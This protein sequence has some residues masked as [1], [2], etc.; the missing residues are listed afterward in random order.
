MNCEICGKTTPLKITDKLEINGG[1]VAG[2]EHL[3][4]MIHHQHVEVPLCEEHMR[5]PKLIRNE[6]LHQQRA[7]VIEA[8]KA[9]E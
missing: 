2:K 7:K 5:E 4:P 3:P 6:E 8:L 1:H 9:A